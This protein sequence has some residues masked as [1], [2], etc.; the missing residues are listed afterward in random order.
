MAGLVC[1]TGGSLELDIKKREE[2]YVHP[3]FDSS[4]IIAD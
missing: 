2:L 3:A 1:D 4:S